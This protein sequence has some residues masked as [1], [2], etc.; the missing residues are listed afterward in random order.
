MP[1]IKVAPRFT[2]PEIV[3]LRVRQSSS[4][5]SLILHAY[6]TAVILVNFSLLFLNGYEADL[7]Y[8]ADW[9]RKLSRNGYSGFDGNYPPL[10]IHWLFVISK[11]Y[12]LVDVPIEANDFLK[13]L[14]QLP[15]TL[16]HCLLSTVMYL[17]LK[18][19]NAQQYLLHMVMM[20]TVFNPCILVNGPIWGQVDLIPATIIVC[21]ILVGC[22]GRRG[23]LA[24]P[25][26]ILALLTKFQMIA[27]APVF[28]AMFFRDVKK[29]MLGV[30]VSLVL[31]V[32]VFAPYIIAGNILQ[33]FNLAYVETLGQY[34]M[35]TFNA[36]NIWMLLAGNTAPDNQILFGVTED[37][38]FAKLFTAKYF[39]MFLFALTAVWVFIQGIYRNVDSSG[40]GALQANI[41]QP[42][43]SALL[44]AMAFFA[45]LPAM[46]ERYLFPAAI[47]ALAYTAA[48]QQKLVYPI[49]ISM[50]CGLNMIIVLDLNGSDIW[51]GLAWLVLLMLAF[52]LL[53]SIFGEMVFRRLKNICVLVYKT[54]FLSVW[55][56]AVTVPVMFY[57][58]Y[59][60]YHINVLSLSEKQMFLTDLPPVYAV[61]DHGNLAVNHSFDGNWLSVNNRRYAQ[62]LGTHSNSNIGFQLPAN[63]SKFSFIV[64]LDDEVFG[65]GD[66]KFS[67]WGDG[68]LLLESKVFGKFGQKSK[69][70]RIDVRGVKTLNL[71]VAA[72]EHDKWD[73]ADWVNTVLELAP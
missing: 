51:Q 67:V 57:A 22:Y 2:L 25:L 53:E 68:I 43:F 34:P 40:I 9:A 12:S 72:L 28:S 19:F 46:H 18:R 3:L 24:I 33:A 44:C 16:S 50:I 58:F 27:F 37:Y 56:F 6:L 23:Y 73:H 42:L 17:L 30:G 63:A 62:G 70:Y 32:V 49:A 64:G 35:A 4:K 7:A 20:L 29:N 59:A 5:S 45:L 15:V 36:A 10:Y 54:P 41:A 14:T 60:R 13:F 66:V 69:E 11:L 39:G 31:I 47:I 65:Q 1:L 26:F 38:E 21:A 55:V 52:C 71:K 48:T 61:Q 8:W